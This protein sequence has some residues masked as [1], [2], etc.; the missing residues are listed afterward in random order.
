VPDADTFALIRIFFGYELIQ[1]RLPVRKIN[2]F[3]SVVLGLTLVVMSVAH[4]ES[5]QATLQNIPSNVAVVYLPGTKEAGA[6]TTGAAL[7]NEVKWFHQRLVKSLNINQDIAFGVNYYYS[8][9]NGGWKARVKTSGS[10]APEILPALDYVSG[11]SGCQPRKTSSTSSVLEHAYYLA[12]LLSAELGKQPGKKFLVIGHSQGAALAKLVWIL[13]L[14][15]KRDT[16]ASQLKPD[17]LRPQCWP[18]NL[19][20]AMFYGQIYMGAPISGTAVSKFDTEMGDKCSAGGTLNPSTNEMCEIVVKTRRTWKVLQSETAK[21]AQSIAYGGWKSESIFI[22]SPVSFISDQEFKIPWQLT[23]ANKVTKN[24]VIMPS[25][26][27]TPMSHEWWWHPNKDISGS[28]PR[29]FSLVSGVY[30]AWSDAQGAFSTN[31]PGAKPIFKEGA[32]GWTRPKGG[33]LPGDIYDLI[34]MRIKLDWS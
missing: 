14:K 1:G 29:W 3:A 8:S 26:G 11:T 23:A 18:P 10:E 6:G 34:I 28:C 12:W 4:P 24:V 31:N 2:A 7:Q 32:L 9:S 21:P 22:K 15:S 25:A 16:L 30:C 13:A 19:T 5:A 17:T 33:G 20:R 27:G